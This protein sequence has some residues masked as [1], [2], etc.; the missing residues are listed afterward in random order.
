MKSAKG[1]VAAKVLLGLCLLGAWV[2]APANAAPPE[3]KGP[4]M[5]TASVFYP[6]RLIARAKTNAA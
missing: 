3:K 5:K 6:A 4:A 2:A 1:Q